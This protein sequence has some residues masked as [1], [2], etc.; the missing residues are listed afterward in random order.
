MNKFLA[1][2]QNTFLGILEV[3][4]P[5]RTEKNA[6]TFIDKQKEPHWLVRLLNSPVRKKKS[7]KK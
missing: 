4:G 7:E 1:V 3:Y 6:E 5:F 2:K